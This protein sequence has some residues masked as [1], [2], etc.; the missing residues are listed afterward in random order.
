MPDREKVIKGLSICNSLT[1]ICYNHGCPYYNGV[2]DICGEIEDVGYSYGDCKEKL[3]ND[4]IALLKEQDAVEPKF[5]K[6]KVPEKCGECRSCN[7]AITGSS[8]CR[9]ETASLVNSQMDIS[10]I[11]V[12]VDS[13]PVWCPIIKANN[14]L[15]RMPFEKRAEL[16]KL[17]TGLSPWIGG[18]DL[19]E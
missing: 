17:I 8:Y 15:D 1:D 13:R 2:Q 18:E 10:S 5:K 14:E 4:A 6:L 3:H 11:Y 9:T 19:W 12:N 16:E 7:T